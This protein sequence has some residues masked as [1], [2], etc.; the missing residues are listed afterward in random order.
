MRREKGRRMNP[1]SAYIG[2][3]NK[4]S[5]FTN[6]PKSPFRKIKQIYG[7]QLE[8]LKLENSYSHKDHSKLLTQHKKE[9]RERVRKQI[10]KDKKQNYIII[11][12]L[13]FII[14]IMIVF[15]NYYLPKFI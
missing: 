3:G 6:R 14:L 4:T 15:I 10:E 8:R 1:V 13:F 5:F 9:I 2:S 12:V 7:E 11:V